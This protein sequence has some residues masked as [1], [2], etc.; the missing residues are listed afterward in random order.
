MGITWSISQKQRLKELHADAA[1]LEQ[2]FDSDK[3]RD[4]CYQKLDKELVSVNRDRLVSLKNSGA[5]PLVCELESKLVKKLTDEGFVQVTTPIILSKSML[6]KMT[7]TSDHPLAKQVFWVDKNKCLRPMLAPNLYEV[8]RDLERV[9]GDPVRIFEVGPCFRK[10]SQGAQHMNEFT[11][12]NLVELGVPDGQQDQRLKELMVLAMEA[13]GIEN[14]QLEKTES[15]VYGDTIDVVCRDLEVASGSY[16]PI[17]MDHNWGI[18]KPWVGVGFGLERLA[19][20][21]EGHNN[22]R[23]VSRNLSYLSGARLNI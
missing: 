3:E 5:R 1:V 17:S 21:I 2:V 18:F 20:T 15:E 13:V 9:W 4:K 23:R 12:L 8:M 11:M 16:G 19:M 14:Y 6:D 7:I 22:I 10:E